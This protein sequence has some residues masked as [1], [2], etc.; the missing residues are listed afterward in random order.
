VDGLGSRTI[1]GGVDRDRARSIT[2]S[3]LEIEL[4]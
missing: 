2:L 3:A 1:M 4:A